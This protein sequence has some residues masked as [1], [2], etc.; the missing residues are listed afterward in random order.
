M[1]RA[2]R[3]PA[4]DVKRRLMAVCEELGQEATGMMR[5]IDDVR[6][7][8]VSTPTVELIACVPISGNWPETIDIRCGTSDRMFDPCL[9]GRSH[10]PFE[11]LAS[12]L[13][14]TLQE[15]EQVI[16]AIRL[17]IEGPFRF[18]RSVW[19]TPETLS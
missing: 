9:R 17:G 19:A 3:E 13:R 11:D 5:L 14:E 18:E 8:L 16:A 2:G 1:G 10:V 7:I 6:V 15:R 4:E 12:A